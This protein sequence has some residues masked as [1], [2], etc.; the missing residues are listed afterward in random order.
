MLLSF[1]ILDPRSFRCGNSWAIE[2]SD[3]GIWS[4]DKAL[5]IF[6]LFI[7]LSVY[8]ITGS[9]SGGYEEFCILEGGDAVV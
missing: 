8:R 1:Q 3:I 2:A 5:E 6:L 7:I 9:Y 4:T